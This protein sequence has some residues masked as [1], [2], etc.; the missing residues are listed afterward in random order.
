[1]KLPHSTLLLILLAGLPF[2]QAWADKDSRNGDAVGI[3]EGTAE[4]DGDIVTVRTIIQLDSDGELSGS[5]ILRKKDNDE[6]GKLMLFV[7]ESKYTLVC[8]WAHPKGSGYM[9]IL[10]SAAYYKFSGWWGPD[11]ELLDSAWNGV[12]IQE[13]QDGNEDE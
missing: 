10:F 4:S 6:T 8:R 3:Y 13:K 12:S 5:Y 11:L 2:T 7:W 9:R 1:M